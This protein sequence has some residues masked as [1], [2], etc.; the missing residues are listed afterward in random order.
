MKAKKQSSI[1]LA[2]CLTLGTLAACTPGDI[3]NAVTELNTP[4]S[5]TP[6]AAPAVPSEPAETSSGSSASSSVPSSGEKN[7]TAEIEAFRQEFATRGQTYQGA[8]QMMFKA[9][10]VI[11]E[12]IKKGEH[13]LALTL[14]GKQMSL[15][16]SSPSGYDVG[17]SVRFLLQQIESKPHIVPSYLGGTPEKAYADADLRNLPVKFATHGEFVAGVRINNTLEE[18]GAT[19]GQI[20]FLSGGKDLPTIAYLEKNPS[21]LWKIDPRTISNIATGVK[22]PPRTD[23]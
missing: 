1:I 21:G 16:E 7:Y 22:A 8:L 14:N 11:N 3:I 13:L 19:Q 18:A 6:S 2:A 10:L 23:F 12:D 4:A 5:A 9:L 17:N 15:S 20:Y